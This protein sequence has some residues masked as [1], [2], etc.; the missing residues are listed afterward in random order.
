MTLTDLRRERDAA[1]ANAHASMNRLVGAGRWLVRRPG[2]PWAGVAGLAVW[3]LALAGNPAQDTVVYGVY[4]GVAVVVPGVLLHRALAGSRSLPEDIGF[5]TVLGLAWQLIGWFV[6]TALQAQALLWAWPG[7]TLAL[8]ALAPRLRKHWRGAPQGAP[9][10][11]SWAAS[12]SVAVALVMLYITWLR[13]T[14]LPPF[15]RLVEPDLWYHLSING[16]LTRTVVP[17]LPYVAGERLS[18]HW[19][20]NAHMASGHMMTGIDAPAIL[21]HLWLPPVVLTLFLLICGLSRWLTRLW[22]PGLVAATFTVSLPVA[23]AIT[24]V[25]VGGGYSPI[26]YA[27]PSSVF[28]GIVMV[29]LSR[30]VLGLLQQ[31][32][33][34]GAWAAFVLLTLLAAG[35]KPTILPLCIAGTAVAVAALLVWRR[36]VRVAATVLSVLGVGL[37]GGALSVIGGAAGSEVRLFGYFRLLKEFRTATG[38]DSVQGVTGSWVVPGVLDSGLAGWTLAAAL[39]A[40]MLLYHLPSLLGL[41]GLLMRAVRSDVAV[42]WLAGAVVASYGPLYLIDHMGGS[43][44]YFM[45]TALPLGTILTAHVIALTLPTRRGFAFRWSVVGTAVAGAIAASASAGVFGGVEWRGIPS[46]VVSLAVPIG[47]FTVMA[48]SVVI[49]AHWWAGK[50]ARRAYSMVLI[51]S[52]V[53]GWSVPHLLAMVVGEYLETSRESDSVAVAGPVLPAPK[54]RAALWLSSHA[55]EEEVIV[56][57]AHCFKFKGPGMCDAR[58]FSLSALSG[59]RVLLEGWGYTADNA[60]TRTRSALSYEFQPSPW[61]RRLA[62]SDAAVTSPTR[63]LLDRLARRHGVRWVFADKTADQP[64]PALFDMATLRYENRDVAIF[65]LSTTR[66]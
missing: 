4:W 16:E 23:I 32:P 9:L 42:W 51:G 62:Q 17:Q 54:Q 30:S 20:A 28:A 8:F 25:D 10:A 1:E 14:A 15:T 41:S 40:A 49:A 44:K 29:A 61:P 52:L 2:L 13:D 55:G 48:G 46:A 26:V 56:T 22:W 47:L 38:D 50:I 18:Y 58:G 65:R 64:D 36:S 5:G 19:F 57:N 31:H 6:L 7:A 59:R 33:T 35:T 45:V 24:S 63:P 43:Q 27:S 3:L 53:L 66:R 37:L 11:W 39:V 34:K 12:A 60:L 21:L